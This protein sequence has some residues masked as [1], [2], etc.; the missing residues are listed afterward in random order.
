MYETLSIA[1]ARLDIACHQGNSHSMC[2]LT[3]VFS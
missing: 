3:C 2:T 1:A